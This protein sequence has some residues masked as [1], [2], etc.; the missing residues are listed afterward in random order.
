VSTAYR[1]WAFAGEMVPLRELGE[2]KG[3]STPSKANSG[4][5]SNGTI[6]WVSP[7]D[8]KVDTITSSEDCITKEAVDLG[9]LSIVPSG[10]VLV[11]TRSGILQH[12]LPVAVTTLPVTINQ[13]I[14]ALVPRSKVSPK[15]VALALQAYAREILSSCSKHGTTVSSVETNKLLDF[16]IP[17]VSPAQQNS[18]VAEIEKQFSRLDEAVANLKRVKASLKRYKAAVLK[19]AVEGRLVPTEAELARKEGRTYETGE[20]LLARILQERRAAWE[21]QNAGWRRK[22]YNEPQMPDS[23]NWPAL[24]KGWAWTS[25]D[26]LANRITSG[27]RD[28]S[29]YYGRGKSV[30]VLAQNVRPL[31]PDFTITQF[32]EPPADDP[33]CDRSRIQ[34]YDLLVTIVGANTGQVCMVKTLPSEAYVCQSVALIRPVFN[35]FAMYLNFWLNSEKHGQLYFDKCLYGQGRPHL[36]FEQLLAAPIAAPPL[37]EQNRI[38]TEVDRHFSIVD[39][40]ETQVNANFQRGER[41]RQTI[42]QQAFQSEPS[43]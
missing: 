3:G 30:F 27:S 1:T 40:L 24:P 18:I 10:S 7:K 19:A 37:A 36:S 43:T 23:S 35:C 32:V 14:K 6:P 21:K 31:T 38:V 29:P 9:R 5:W 28:W 13:D 2:W 22:N 4:F 12:T 42:L 39:E 17:L 25:L 8:M 15:Y 11:V 20:Q 16:C 33:A 41:L 26:Q 34:P